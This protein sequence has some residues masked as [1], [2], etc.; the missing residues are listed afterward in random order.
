[1]FLELNVLLVVPEILAGGD[2][3]LFLHDVDPRDLLRDGMFDLDPGVHLNEEKLAG[4]IEQKF[5]GS[6]V[7]IPN[8]FGPLDRRLAHF[9][10]DIVGESR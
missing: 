6:G 7:H 3:N 8:R 1:M 10:A 2:A 4:G 5:D 9:L